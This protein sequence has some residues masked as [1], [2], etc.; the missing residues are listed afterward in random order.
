MRSALP[1]SATVPSRRQPPCG[2]IYGLLS[3]QRGW[4]YEVWALDAIEVHYRNDRGREQ[5]IRIGTNDADGLDDAL[6][7]V[8]IGARSGHR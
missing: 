8:T 4:C 2:L 5:M 7:E 3:D 6:T 1:G